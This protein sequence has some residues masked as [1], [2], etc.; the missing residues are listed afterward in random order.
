MRHMVMHAEGPER[1]AME[2]WRDEAGKRADARLLSRRESRGFARLDFSRVAET[3][4]Q[5]DQ[6]REDQEQEF[7]PPTDNRLVCARRVRMSNVVPVSAGARRRADGLTSADPPPTR[8]SPSPPTSRSCAAPR[9]RKEFILQALALGLTGI[10]IADRNSV[11]GVVR[12]YSALDEWN[13]HIASEKENG[14]ELPTVKA[15]CRRAARLRRRHAR[16]PRLSAEPR[17]LGPA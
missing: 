14:N 11:A 2:W 15:R 6:E 13:E 7:G 12:A 10:G 1:I 17:R 8:S 4:T 5:E 3:A 9:M 16:H